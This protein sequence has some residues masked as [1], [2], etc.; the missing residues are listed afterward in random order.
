M[1]SFRAEI[2][3]CE[4]CGGAAREISG[5]RRGAVL[6]RHLREARDSRDDIG[7]DVV[8]VRCLWACTRSC[9]VMLR[10]RSR[11]G[12]VVADLE[13]SAESARGLLDY[14][15]LYVASADGSVPYKLWPPVLK[16]HFLCRIPLLDSSLAESGSLCAQSALDSPNPE[17]E[18]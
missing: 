7:V 8:S 2:V 10:S 9:A 6:L 13:P 18:P 12:Y 11:V 3:A 14:A 5:E 17:R 15:E 4:T 1:R 16:G